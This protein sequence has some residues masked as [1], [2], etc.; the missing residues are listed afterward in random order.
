[1]TLRKTIRYWRKA[2]EA[3]GVVADQLGW[4]QSFTE[5]RPVGGGGEAIPWYT[6]PAIEFIRTLD[7]ADARVFEYGCGNSSIFWAARVHEVFAVESDTKWARVVRGFGVP[8]LA[9]MEADDKDSY[10]AAPIQV[11]GTFDIVVID[12]KHRRACVDVAC[13]VIKD[14]GIVIFDNADWYPDACAELRARGWF[15]IDFSG[16]GPITPFPWTTAVFIMSNA[17]FGRNNGYKLVGASTPVWHS[18]D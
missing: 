13:Q 5:G 9:V 10:V 11:G 17:S 1:M 8:N 18:D 16:L 3:W 7:L 2:L 14:S 12:G 4:K 15:Q 6:Y